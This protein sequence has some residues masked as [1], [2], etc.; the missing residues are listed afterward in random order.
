MVVLY[1]GGLSDGNSH[2]HDNLPVVLVGGA[3][4]QMKGGRHVRY[5]K[6]TPM[7]NLLLTMLDMV[8]CSRTSSAT[9]RAVSAWLGA[10]HLAARTRGVRQRAAY[11]FGGSRPRSPRLTR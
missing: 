10:Y 5:P 4:G 3:S 9:A 7:P 11:F 2:L 8:G 1:G 6:D